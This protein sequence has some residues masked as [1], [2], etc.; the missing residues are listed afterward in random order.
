M[1]RGAAVQADADPDAELVEQV[2]EAASRRTPLVWMLTLAVHLRRQ[3]RGG[4][5]DRVADDTSGAGEQ[6]LAAVQDHL[7]RRQLVGAGVLGDARGRRLDGGRRHDRGWPRQD[8]SA[9]VYM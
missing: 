6:R 4:A 3:R 5:R 8:W 1:R 7:D 9:I 2:E